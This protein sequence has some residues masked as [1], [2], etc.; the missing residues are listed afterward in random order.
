MWYGSSMDYN[1]QVKKWAASKLDGVVVADIESVEFE[2]EEGHW[3]SE[4]TY[5]EGYASAVVHM[6]HGPDREITIN[7]YDFGGLIHEVMAA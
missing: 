3:Y 2:L 7:K 5:D 1:L 4:Y 6:H